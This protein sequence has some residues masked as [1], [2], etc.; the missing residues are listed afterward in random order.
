MCVRLSCSLL[1]GLPGGLGCA[2]CLSLTTVQD[3]SSKYGL[4]FFSIRRRDGVA[5]DRQTAQNRGVPGVSQ[6]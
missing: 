5:T 2:V 4:Q 1:T 3:G 6:A